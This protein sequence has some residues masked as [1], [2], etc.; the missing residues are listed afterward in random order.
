METLEP[1]GKGAE[2]TPKMLP[3]GQISDIF[4]ETYFWFEKD[5]K[6]LQKF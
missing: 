3:E 5:M 6:R 2:S 4:Q 1:E